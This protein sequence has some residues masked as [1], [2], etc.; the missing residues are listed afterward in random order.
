VEAEFHELEGDGGD[1]KEEA[2]SEAEGKGGYHGDA[3]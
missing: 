3:G 1:R 2:A